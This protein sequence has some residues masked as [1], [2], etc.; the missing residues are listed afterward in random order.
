MFR[1]K[2]SKKSESSVDIH[3]EI[4]YE[5]QKY[6]NEDKKLVASI[7]N[8]IKT[9]YEKLLRY[10]LL[11]INLERIRI[12]KSLSRYKDTANKKNEL[13]KLIFLL[14]ITGMLN[15]LL[16]YFEATGKGL[17]LPIGFEYIIY[18]GL[19][20]YLL[21]SLIKEDIKYKSAE[22]DLVNNISLIVLDDIEKSM[23]EDIKYK[24]I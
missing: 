5:Y 2:K 23:S 3:K 8:E 4:F 17:G 15:G 10:G 21:F 12:N 24:E 19:N 22:K 20:M 6:N 11:N 18:I 9:D 7:Y 14:A 1:R 16:K 13:N